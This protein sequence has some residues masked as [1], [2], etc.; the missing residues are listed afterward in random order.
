[1]RFIQKPTNNGIVETERETLHISDDKQK[2][3]LIDYDIINPTQTI[4]YQITNHLDSAS[5]ELDENGAIISYEEYHPFGT[6]SYR[7]GRNEIDVFLKRYKYVVL[8]SI[9]FL[10]INL[11][12]L[13]SLN[14][15]SV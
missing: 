3:A 14:R 10:F 1:M 6:R 15:K 9:F 11:S 12:S 13:M 5:L 4:R 8:I 2:V 7:S